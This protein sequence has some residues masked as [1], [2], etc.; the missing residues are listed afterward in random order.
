MLWRRGRRLELLHLRQVCVGVG[1]GLG[2]AAARLAC[3]S[4]LAEAVERGSEPEERATAARLA[5]ERFAVLLLGG[6]MV[7]EREWTI[8][9]ISGVPR[10]TDR[11]FSD[12]P[13]RPHAHS[14]D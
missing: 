1:P 2:R 14:G 3:V 8:G 9:N 6:R 5:G 12:P 13:E 4:G 10:L 11:R 7:T